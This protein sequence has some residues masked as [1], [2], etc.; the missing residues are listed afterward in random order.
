MFLGFFEKVIEHLGIAS[1]KHRKALVTRPLVMD[2]VMESS[3][4]SYVLPINLL[5][6]VCVPVI[7]LHH[8]NFVA[9]CDVSCILSHS[10]GLTILCQTVV[11][12]IF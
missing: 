3:T 8:V 5:L 11:F 6:I 4:R 7:E 12:Y 2:G 9:R 10:D 1:W